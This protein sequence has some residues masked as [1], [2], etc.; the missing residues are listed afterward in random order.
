MNRNRISSSEEESDDAS[1]QQVE[2]SDDEERPTAQRQSSG[3]ES[4]D[5]KVKSKR[6]T[7]AAKSSANVIESGSSESDSDGEAYRPET[8][9]KR[10]PSK[11]ETGRPNKKTKT[12]NSSDEEGHAPRVDEFD[13]DMIADEDDRERLNMMSEKEREIEIFKRIERRELL[14]AREEI[15]QKLTHKD[16]D[17][18]DEKAAKNKKKHKEKKTEKPKK[19]TKIE[20][21]SDA[22]DSTEEL[23]GTSSG[24]NKAR[25]VSSDDE[26]DMAYHRPSEVAKK[27]T[28]KKALDFLKNKRKEKREADEK[29]KMQAEKATLDID[30]VFGVDG[31]GDAKSS[32]SGSSSPSRS[33]S[34]SRSSGGSSES[35]RGSSP[36]VKPEINSV[37]ELKR[38]RLSRFKLSQWCHTPFFN[39]LAVGCFVRVQIGNDPAKQAPIYRVAQ[40]KE[41][42]ETAK[43]YPLE[44]TRTN[45]GLRLQHG[46]DSKVFR[47]MFVSNSEFTDGEFLKWVE[48]MKKSGNALPTIDAIE[49][50]EEEIKKAITYKMTEQD[51]DYMVK[52]KARFKSDPVNSAL[53]KSELQKRKVGLNFLLCKF[54]YQ[55]SK[56]SFR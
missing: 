54:E 51:I 31:D 22:E 50:K 6:R 26:V 47:M 2:S 20:E 38:I 48:N 46:A 30:D 53:Q 18:E 39:K 41:V 14:K 45:K 8:S 19:K 15:K 36:E 37:N 23:I 25:R 28:T 21:D 13:D 35:S 40:V 12:L 27:Q 34:R 42:V 9:K 49:R 43:V 5:A 33:R 1:P 17:S 29:R 11:T 55:E 7:R 52:E 16:Q 24:K 32:S 10:R 4:D 3:S 56:F 44:K